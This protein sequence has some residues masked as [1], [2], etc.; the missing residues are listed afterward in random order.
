MGAPQRLLP[1][2]FSGSAWVPC[3]LGNPLPP[4]LG[5]PWARS[6]G[7]W[8]VVRPPVVDIADGDLTAVWIGAEFLEGPGK[9]QCC[10]ADLI[11][12][13]RF[14]VPGHI[15]L[16]GDSKDSRCLHRHHHS[17]LTSAVVP[18]SRQR[19]A[20]GSSAAPGEKLPAVPGRAYCQ[21]A[22]AAV[23]TGHPGECCREVNPEGD[24][25]LAIPGGKAF[26]FTPPD[27]IP[28]VQVIQDLELL[29]VALSAFLALLAV[30]AVGYAL[31]MAVG[32]RRH[33][34]AVLP[35]LGIT[36]R[37]ARPVITTQASLLALIGLTARTARA[38]PADHGTGS[39]SNATN[40]NGPE[41]GIQVQVGE[42][43][44]VA[45]AR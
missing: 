27:P 4:R 22:A 19:T 26:T 35:A 21:P 45:A 36:P 14:D 38:C 11:R 15:H 30:S 12:L 37:P 18:A 20:P 8:I 32:R 43:V 33:D 17:C 6:P 7:I 42:E 34:L 29:P 9:L 1:R 44:E 2:E 16:D 23:G 28:E 25:S 10:G 24:G 3:C 5:F 41:S 13:V 39:R 31:S 40:A